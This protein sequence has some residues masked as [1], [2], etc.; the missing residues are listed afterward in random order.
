MFSLKLL[1]KNIG[2]RGRLTE[3]EHLFLCRAQLQGISYVT[4]V[5][6]LDH[7]LSCALI[8]VG[9]MTAA[10]CNQNT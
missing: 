2:H 8:S 3:K 7:P 5:H 1:N 6:A 4:Y 10:F 9:I